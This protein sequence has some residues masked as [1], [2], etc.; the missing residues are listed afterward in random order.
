MSVLSML[1]DAID[2][3][4]ALGAC[5]MSSN[6]DRISVDRNGDWKAIF[7]ILQ[8]GQEALG[9]VRRGAEPWGALIYEE[10]T[11]YIR[12]G[13][14]GRKT[15]LDQRKVRAALGLPEPVGQPRKGYELREVFSVRIEPSLAQYLKEL[16]GDN[17]SEGVAIA[18]NAHRKAA[19]RSNKASTRVFTFPDRD[20][21]YG[22][23]TVRFLAL[24]GD[25]VHECRIS[26]EALRDY[27]GAESMKVRDLLIGFIAGKT[28]IHKVARQKLSSGAAECLLT[29][30]DFEYLR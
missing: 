2:T 9:T 4:G 20:A 21:V 15:V 30:A 27:F 6:R 23:G 17:L 8:P 22:E 19:E 26:A 7:Q 14:A 10:G 3:E 12:V 18:G 29:T 13:E 1:T 5:D 28:E 11:G 24:E 25:Q 16:G